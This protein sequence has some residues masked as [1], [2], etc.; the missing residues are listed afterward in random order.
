MC[1]SCNLGKRNIEISCKLVCPERKQCSWFQMLSLLEHM[2]H[3]LDLV[4]EFNI[5]PITLKRWLVRH[6]KAKEEKTEPKFSPWNILLSSV[7]HDK[8]VEMAIFLSIKKWFCPVFDINPFWILWHNSLVGI[9]LGNFAQFYRI[10]PLDEFPLR[11]K[12]R[13]M[14]VNRNVEY[15]DVL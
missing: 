8:V 15:L 14:P 3:E 10:M 6:L 4:H 5:N 2:Y 1:Y 9:I 12:E 13:K 7:F 11:I